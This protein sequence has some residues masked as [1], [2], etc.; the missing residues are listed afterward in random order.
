MKL[1][2]SNSLSSNKMPKS[3]L[4]LPTSE[5][6]AVA[7]YKAGAGLTLTGVSVDSWENQINSNYYMLQDT[8]TEKPTF[9][10]IDNSIYFDGG[11]FLQTTGQINLESEF[12]IGIRI[13]FDGNF[14]GTML[15]DNTT[16]NE[17]FKIQ[18]NDKIRLKNANGSRDFDLSTG[19]FGDDYLVLSRNASNIISLYQNGTL[20]ENETL[21][22]DI[23]I[24]T[25][26]TK[27]IDTNK[28]TGY[29]YEIMIFNSSSAELTNNINT[30]LATL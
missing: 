28:I 1:T 12:T 2:L 18:E 26:G 30:R 5:G 13:N 16:A 7:W 14:N 17:M 8:D 27:Y 6:S 21:G 29:I 3:S 24:D 10:N 15:G 23:L 4:W 19:V 9:S 20:V 11:D 25:I 22:N